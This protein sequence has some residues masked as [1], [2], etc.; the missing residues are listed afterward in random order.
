MRVFFN[1]SVIMLL[2][3]GGKV[4]A[5]SK[6]QFNEQLKKELSDAV[7][8]YNSM[9]D[10]YTLS[11]GALENQRMQVRSKVVREIQGKIAEV[12]ILKSTVTSL[13]SKLELLGEQPEKLVAKDQFNSPIPSLEEGLIGSSNALT[14]R[15]VFRMVRD[16]LQWN[17]MRVK[18]QNQVLPLLLADYSKAK[19][20]NEESLKRIGEYKT[21]LD[22]L[23]G[24]IDS[25]AIE[26]KK[27]N[28]QLTTAKKILLARYEELRA[29]Y[30]KNPNGYSKAYVVEFGKKEMLRK[31]EEHRFGND[32]AKEENYE[33]LVPKENVTDLMIYDAVDVPAEFPGGISAMK[34]YLQKSFVL[35]ESVRSGKIGGK[36]YLKFVVSTSGNVSNVKVVKGVPDCPECDAEAIRVVKAMPDWK[37]AKNNGK[38]VNCFFTLPI[39]F[40]P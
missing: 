35:P 27:R 39:S 14:N 13:Y 32:F 20:A 31:Q 2:A 19:E 33:V 1:F 5:Q 18:E 26:L 28:E 6:K 4:F 11:Y 23:N 9:K 15:I 30:D 25:V 17:E 37:P 21:A 12:Q 22:N 36:C 16:T 29:N 40:N 34:E 10:I 38:P 3:C 7:Q 24:R 8:Q